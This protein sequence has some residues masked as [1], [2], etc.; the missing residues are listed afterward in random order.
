M[1]LKQ[2]MTYLGTACVAV[3][4]SVLLA[5]CPS[6]RGGS[7]SDRGPIRV[8]VLLSQT[9]TIGPYGQRALKGVQLA[10]SQINQKGLL[11][12]RKVA[13]FTQDAQSS[14]KEAVSAY[15][16]LT[17]V[18]NVK[19]VLGDI[20]ST[21]SL[22]VAPLAESDHV[23]M[24]APGASNPK[25]RYMGDYIFRNWTSD[26][27]D[28]RALA[29]YA[30]NKMK[31][32]SSAIIYQQT[33]YTAGLSKAFSSH[34]T[35]LGGTVGS[36]ETISDG[37]SD[38]RQAVTKVLSSQP[39]TI[40]VCAMSKE[41]GVVVKFLRENGFKGQILATLSV[42]SPE[43]FKLAKND[44]NGI[45]FSTPAFDPTDKSPRVAEFVS[46][47]K[48]KFG[49]APDVAAAHAYDAMEILAYAIT[50]AGSDEP[51]KIR[52]AIYNIKNFPGVTGRTTFDKMGDVTK[53]II[54]KEISNGNAKSLEKYDVQPEKGKGL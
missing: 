25:F 15:R 44:A 30:Y 40:F 17:S 34:L 2:V 23:L 36:S 31:I 14:A 42:D 21:T 33:D 8:G 1:K 7:G 19:I 50:K 46:V 35:S 47:Y 37:A 39:S 51:N 16:K 43:F 6:K 38:A 3:G 52:D 22:A 24:M 53:P 32:T 45:V 48:E 20:Y 13:I 29:D 26:E 41:S 18:D 4:C 10:V 5:G 27:F 9:G 28:G 49:S 12:G 11:N 54:I